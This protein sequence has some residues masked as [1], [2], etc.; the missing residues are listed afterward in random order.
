MMSGLDG[1]KL[2]SRVIDKNIQR[3]LLTGVADDKD[4][5]DAFNNGYINRFIK[6]GSNNFNACINDSVAKAVNQYFSIYTD[7]LLQHVSIVNGTHLSD[8]IFAK[9]FYNI[10]SSGD[11]VEYYMLDVF[12]SYLFVKTNGDV[13]M[14]SVLTE[15]EICRII[16]VG[17]ESGEIEEEVLQKL[18]SRKY[19]LA[20]HSCSGSLPLIAEWKNYLRPAERLDGYQTYYFSILGRESLDIAVDVIESLDSFRRSRKI[21]ALQN[22]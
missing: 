11:F 13:Q 15:S 10:I 16:D 12:G 9:F 6:K 5:I 21:S 8:P 19:M 20:Y 22:L 3:I 1:V 17:V 14:L 18:E 7:Y 2:C 4:G